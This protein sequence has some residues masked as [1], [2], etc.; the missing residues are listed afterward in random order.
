MFTESVSQIILFLVDTSSIAHLF[1]IC[2]K[3]AKYIKIDEKWDLI[4]NKN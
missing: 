1:Q 2:V 4:C 3:K